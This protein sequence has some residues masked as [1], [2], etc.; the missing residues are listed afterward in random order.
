MLQWKP[1]LVLVLVSGVA[2]ALTAG[3]NHGWLLLLNHSW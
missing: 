3:L 2:L 1:R